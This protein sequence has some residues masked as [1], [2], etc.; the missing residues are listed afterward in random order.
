MITIG[1]ST[2]CWHCDVPVQNSLTVTST[3]KSEQLEFYQLKAL[4]LLLL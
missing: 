1:V 4:D 2:I 3:V